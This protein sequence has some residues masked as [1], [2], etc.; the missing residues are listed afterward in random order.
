MNPEE[1]PIYPNIPVP[2]AT[3]I[4]ETVRITSE[5]PDGTLSVSEFSLEDI[6]RLRDNTSQHLTRLRAEY[7]S[8]DI[9]NEVEK[10]AWYEWFIPF[11]EQSL[12]FYE[13]II[14]TYEGL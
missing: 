5:D 3:I 2:E 4:D 14:Q 7:A 13:E 12:I 10:A 11:S 1:L 8:L 6:L 9:E